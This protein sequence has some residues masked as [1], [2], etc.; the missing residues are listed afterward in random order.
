[1]EKFK[2]LVNT[3]NKNIE[4]FDNLDIVQLNAKHTLVKGLKRVLHNIVTDMFDVEYEKT[5]DNV[6]D[7][8]LQRL[9]DLN[10]IILFSIETLKMTNE[11]IIKLKLQAIIYD[12]LRVI[13]DKTRK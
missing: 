1:M 3:C 4:V 10:Q 2:S 7:I 12:E 5:V 9:T 6:N 11:N 13:Y 8:I